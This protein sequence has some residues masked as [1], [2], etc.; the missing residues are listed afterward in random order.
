MNRL[1][2]GLGSGRCGTK[3]LH[4]LLNKQPR[5]ASIH[6][7]KPLLSY[8]FDAAMFRAHWMNLT[9]W[10]GTDV[11]APIALF[12]L[13]YV[14]AFL[15]I[16]S[17]VC[18]VCLKR[19]REETIKSW[20]RW[21]SRR[22]IFTHHWTT[23]GRTYWKNKWGWD[24]CFPKYDDCPTKEEAIARYYDHYYR[25]ASVYEEALPNFQ[26]FPM[27]CLNSAQGVR[28]ILDFAGFKHPNIV[29]GI[30]RK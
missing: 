9:G 15:S 2:V 30:K 18:F 19:D 24:V 16:E 26:I 11:V 4:A 17:E 13:W 8:E 28:E 20:M 5:S 6:E 10:K 3:S 25:L 27:E 22:E 21:T 14:P 23:Q 12:Y 1:V 29:I 7:P